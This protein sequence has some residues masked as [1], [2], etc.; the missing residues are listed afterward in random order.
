MKQKLGLF[1]I[2]LVLSVNG[3]AGRFGLWDRVSPI[4]YDEVQYDPRA[5]ILWVSNYLDSKISKFALDGNDA[6]ESATETISLP[7]DILVS[8]VCFSH[9][10][11]F[12]GFNEIS[13]R[14]VIM[15]Y[16]DSV[17]KK[18]DQESV[19]LGCRVAASGE[20]LFW[21]KSVI[22]DVGL[23]DELRSIQGI[24][25]ITIIDAF[26]AEDESL[27][28]LTKEGEIFSSKKSDE[29]ILFAQSSMYKGL[30]VDGSYL[31]V[32]SDSG[33]YR[34]Q[35]SMATQSN[36]ENLLKTPLGV[37]QEIFKDRNGFVWVVTSENLWVWRYDKF[38]M[39]NLPLG[40][41]LIKDYALD[42]ENNILYLSTDQGIYSLKLDE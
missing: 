17:L 4:S 30:Y 20:I 12:A 18:F 35:I 32:T 16:S 26:R 13:G 33:I 28:I 40:V 7:P 11:W 27:W 22:V 25:G 8:Y 34:Y 3:C 31:W 1:L 24:E 23:Q 9:N 37:S 21:E 6:T 38:E 2:F 19:L 41:R 29:W 10:L 39:I 15:G 36:V 14:D 42:F 5:N